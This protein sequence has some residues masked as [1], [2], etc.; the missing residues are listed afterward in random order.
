M[1]YAAAARAGRE[2]GYEK[3][4]TFILEDELGTSLKAAGWVLDGFTNGDSWTRERIGRVRREDQP[5][6]PKKRYIKILNSRETG[7]LIAFNRV[8]ETLRKIDS[9]LGGG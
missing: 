4:Q 8:S 9:N 2:L 3:I 5:Q 6:G 7:L 1:L